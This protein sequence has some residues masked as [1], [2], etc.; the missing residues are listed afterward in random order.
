[1]KKIILIS[2]L[3]IT[4]TPSL[5]FFN[6][7][8]FAREKHRHRSHHEHREEMVETECY[9]VTEPYVSE[10]AANHPGAYSDGYRQGTASAQKGE[11]FK[12]RTAGGEFARGFR[13]GY[14]GER[15]ANQEI[16][17]PD[18]VQYQTVTRC[19]THTIDFRD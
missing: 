9:P 4:T 10:D 5:L 16:E 11:L 12:P 13:D 19:S 1:M 18:R 8:A 3:T 7:T 14:Y 2:L 6:E 17:V 15:F